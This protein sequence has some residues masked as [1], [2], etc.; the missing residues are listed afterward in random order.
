MPKLSP[1]FADLQRVLHTVSVEQRKPA[2]R[3][4]FAT[5]CGESITTRFA[6]DRRISHFCEENWETVVELL[7]GRLDTHGAGDSDRSFAHLPEPFQN[8]SGF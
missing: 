3:L 6:Y 2:N 8:P 5:L 1:L 4:M 7:G